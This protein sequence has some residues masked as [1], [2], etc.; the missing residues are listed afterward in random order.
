MEPCG[1]PLTTSDHSDLKQPSVS[2]PQEN[3]GLIHS[4]RFPDIPQ[5]RSLEIKQ[6]CRTE[7]I[8]IASYV[9]DLLSLGGS[10]EPEGRSYFYKES[11]NT[12]E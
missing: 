11:M 5:L 2:F 10:T 8:I 4:R 6:W 3:S 9:G 12:C 7:S 1:T